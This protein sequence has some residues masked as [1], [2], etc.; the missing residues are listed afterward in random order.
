MET[1]RIGA[2]LANRIG[3]HGSRKTFY[4]SLTAIFLRKKFENKG[5]MKRIRSTCC[6]IG[7]L[8]FSIECTC[9]L[10]LMD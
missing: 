10:G 6:V 7:S 1:I 4:M 8:Y 3:W 9:R 2:L 5:T